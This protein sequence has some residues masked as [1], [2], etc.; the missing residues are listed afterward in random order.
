MP[1]PP[2]FPGVYVEEMTPDWPPPIQALPTSVAAFVGPALQGPFGRAVQILSFTEFE[3][4]FG[5]LSADLETGYALW[6][7]FAN[8]GRVAWVVRIAR[9]AK[10][11]QLAAGL[12]ALAQVGAFNLL[13]LP[14]QTSP[15]ALA[16]AGVLA[17]ERRAFLLMDS[18]A[19][20]Q[21]P[22]QVQQAVHDLQFAPRSH[23]AIYYPWVWLSDPLH[24]A[25]PRLSPP[26]GTIAGLIARIDSTRGVWKAPA[27]PEASLAG[28]TSLERQLT[29]AEAGGLNACGINCLRQFPG[30]AP[31]AWG[32]RTLAGDDQLGS[33]FKYLPV[34]RFALHLQSSLEEGMRWAI[35]E[36]DAEPLWT[37]LRA[38]VE[39]F[40]HT[41]FLQGAFQGASPREAFFVRCGP[42]TSTRP[43]PSAGFINLTIGFAPLRPAEFVVLEIRQ[44]IGSNAP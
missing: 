42:A 37:R 34:R 24:P 35:F 33:D 41:Q 17:Q 25:T 30:H 13:A 28:V 10:P 16:L 29:D 23:A 39:N 2:D 26:S 12:R 38:Q 7:F 22:A 44:S 21:T 15:A 8:G 18:P 11:P 5:G 20:A 43:V 32:A 14:G 3:Q 6:Q 36:P 4:R 9:K 19:L 40:L 31:V 27:G 1:A